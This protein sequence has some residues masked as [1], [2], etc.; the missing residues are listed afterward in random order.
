MEVL[1]TRL[2][3]DVRVLIWKRISRYDMQCV[4]IAHGWD[5]P[6]YLPFKALEEATRR[7]YVSRF[8]FIAERQRIEYSP[9]ERTYSE[10]V[11]CRMAG[12]TG[13]LDLC[14]W[15]TDCGLPSWR[16]VRGAITSQSTEILDHILECCPPSELMLLEYCKIALCT[17]WTEC[18]TWQYRRFGFLP[19]LFNEA[20]FAR[21]PDYLLWLIQHNLF[22]AAVHAYCNSYIP[23]FTEDSC[24]RRVQYV[25]DMVDAAALCRLAS[26]HGADGSHALLHAA[27]GLRCDFLRV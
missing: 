19:I 14:K 20:Y 15:C 23:E 16:I 4:L 12:E 21:L 10:S 2:P 18:F 11:L 7:R 26:E 13:S 24:N 6:G 27:F 5:R 25:V 22:G 17:Q 1:G 3:R 8:K 9:Y